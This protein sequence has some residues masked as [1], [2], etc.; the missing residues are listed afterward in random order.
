MSLLGEGIDE[1]IERETA[2]R[3]KAQDL[4]KGQRAV[5]N[6]L[7][8]RENARDVANIGWIAAGIGLSFLL[9]AAARKQV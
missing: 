9:I 3:P 6:R 4:S 1:A 5:I 2:L 7:H 8:T